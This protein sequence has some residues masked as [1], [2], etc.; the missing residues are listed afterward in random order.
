MQLFNYLLQI[1]SFG[2]IV[3][4][5]FKHSKSDLE[6]D[7]KH[8]LSLELAYRRK[9]EL[10]DIGKE[11]NNFMVYLMILWLANN[12]DYKNIKTNVQEVFGF[13]GNYL[14]IKKKINKWKEYFPGFFYVEE[15][16][17]RNLEVLIEAYF[18]YSKDTSFSV[19]KKISN[20]PKKIFI[21][22]RGSKLFTIHST[23]GYLNEVSM[24]QLI[25]EEFENKF[26]IHLHHQN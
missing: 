22:I 6:I 2:K 16:N 7:C 18:L 14:R 20:T 3:P 4:F 24:E 25:E 9:E 23:T 5:E 21:L 11:S 13:L 1:I 8:S 12:S 26:W 10:K 17:P 15:L 19:Y